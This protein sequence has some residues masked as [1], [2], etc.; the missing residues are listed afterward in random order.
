MGWASGGLD[1]QAPACQIL[2]LTPLGRN[3][4]LTWPPVSDCAS[5]A[6]APAGE[7]AQPQ[8]KKPRLEGPT[9]EAPVPGDEVPAPT[10]WARAATLP[11]RTHLTGRAAA[12]TDLA[13][14]QG[15][16]FTHN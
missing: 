11:L 14:W 1:R 6:C 9:G 10:A 5:P 7:A 2:Q 12:A 8:L 13:R 4:C 3:P 15:A 16:S